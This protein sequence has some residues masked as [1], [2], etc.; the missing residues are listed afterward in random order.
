M[1]AAYVDNDGKVVQL[2][3][4][5]PSKVTIAAKDVQDPEILAQLLQDHED[6]L[7]AL[8]RAWSPKRLFR[9]DLVVDAGAVIKYRIEHGFG[10]LVNWKIAR[11]QPSAAGTECRVTEHTDTDSSALVV[12]SGAAG[13]VTI[14]VEAAG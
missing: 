5:A 4:R 7:S 11:W 10:G 3:G 1:S 6:R 9:R 14:E 2:D 13:T 12:V 8:E